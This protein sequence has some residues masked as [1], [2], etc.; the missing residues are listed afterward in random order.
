MLQLPMI[1]SLVL[2]VS[3]CSGAPLDGLTKRQAPEEEMPPMPVR[4]S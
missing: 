4:K 3:A 1:F 2:L